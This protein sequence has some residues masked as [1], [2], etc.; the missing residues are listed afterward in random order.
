MLRGPRPDAGLN[1]I[2]DAIIKRRED[3]DDPNEQSR[4]SN[5][6]YWFTERVA[7]KLK[8]LETACQGSGATLKDL[9]QA[10]LAAAEALASNALWRAEAGDMAG[11]FVE[12]L[13]A[14]AAGLPPIEPRSYAALFR[15]LALGKAVRLNRSG[16][17]RIAIL[18]PL[19]A[20]LQSFDTVVLG[21]L[22]EGTWPRMPGADPWFS[23]PMRTVLGLEQPERTIGQAAHD[24][25][26]LSA[27]P[28]VVL[29]RALK[30]DGAPTVASRWVQRLEQLARGL[31]LE[32]DLKPE[33]DYAALAKSLREAGPAKRMAKPAPRPPVE[34]RP[35]RL[36]VTDIET[37]VRDPYAIYAKRVLKLRP[38]DPI[39]APVGPLERGT[40]IHRAME[41]FVQ[42]HPGPMVS[43]SLTDLIAISEQVFEEQGVPKA[44]LAVWRPRFAGAAAW[45]VR[46]EAKRRNQIATSHVELKGEAEIADGFT[47]EARADRIDVLTNGH[48]AILDYK[49]GSIP[50]PKQVKAFL[51]PQ[52]PLE[53]AILRTA[54]FGDVGPLETDSLLYVRL[55]GGR[56]PGE[57]RE[58]GIDLVTEITERLKQRIL[59][60]RDPE[61]PYLPR[62]APLKASVPG[63]YDHLSRV[64]EWSLT[65]WGE[66]EEVV[67]E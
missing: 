67:E 61:S 20:R 59:A 17:P 33:R 48:A 45:F 11:R 8:P 39:D 15:R 12:E 38:L 62:V 65:G 64:R 28:R 34:A 9:L 2:R 31:G 46:E 6:L 57:M 66:E 26:M 1:G 54:K 55:C 63:D 21:G 58:I 35:T 37:W 41:L 27:A 53:A 19:E 44:V 52:L 16:H 60:F 14:A 18:G 3:R 36:P 49:T 4:L 30:V 5:L 29:T 50:Q 56:N 25:A 32:Q 43:S 47:L 7:D 23:R 13:M 24:F 10:H 22:N 40:A 51:T 42:N